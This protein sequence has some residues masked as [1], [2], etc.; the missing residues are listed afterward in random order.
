MNGARH[1]GETLV[2]GRVRLPELEQLTNRIHFLL[3]LRH[4]LS[5]LAHE[6]ALDGGTGPNGL[7]LLQE[8]ERPFRRTQRAK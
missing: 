2:D 7:V 4:N 5:E 6:G 1:F 3:K 8:V